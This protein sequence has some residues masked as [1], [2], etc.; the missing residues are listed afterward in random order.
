VAGCILALPENILALPEKWSELLERE[1]EPEKDF[2]G[3]AFWG[4]PAC[5]G[6]Q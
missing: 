6:V 5:G 4:Q 1:S 2:L 3:S